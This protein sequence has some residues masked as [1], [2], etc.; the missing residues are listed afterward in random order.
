MQPVSTDL[1]LERGDDARIYFVLWQKNGDQKIPA[2]VSDSVFDLY[3]SWPGG[4]IVHSTKPDDGLVLTQTD[5]LTEVTWQPSPDDTARL[6]NSP[7]T[8]AFSRTSPDSGRRTYATG[9]IRPLS[10]G[11]SG[12]GDIAI[13]LTLNDVVSLELTDFGIAEAKAAQAGDYAAL[14]EQHAGTAAQQAETATDQAE[15]ATGSASQAAQQA[16]AAAGSA[17]SAGQ[18]A[19][20]AA[21]SASEAQNYAAVIAAAAYDMGTLDQPTDGSI[22][23]DMGSL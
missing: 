18:Q 21:T 6:P 5:S 3:V 17:T 10:W 15:S 22:T 14:A 19:G 16:Q 4:S 8:Y 1:S 9:R 13:T 23:F 2:D 11:Q 12:P 7:V 20:A